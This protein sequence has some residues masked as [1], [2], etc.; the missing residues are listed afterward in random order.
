MYPHFSA[1]RPIILNPPTSF[2]FELQ[3]V[4][5]PSAEMYVEGKLL[6]HEYAD[7]WLNRQVLPHIFG[8]DVN[9]AFDVPSSSL[10][11]LYFRTSIG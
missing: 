3:N 5:Q 6:R 11:A 2:S 7:L 8:L 9:A 4:A 1:L 10:L